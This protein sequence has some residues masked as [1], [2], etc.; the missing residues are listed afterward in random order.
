MGATSADAGSTG[1][2]ARSFGARYVP[3]SDE[4]GELR[5]SGRLTFAETGALWSTLAE[6]QDEACKGGRVD[7]NLEQVELL[8]GGAMA[9]LANFRAHLQERGVRS[10]FLGASE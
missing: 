6:V 9:L 3:H 2:Q 5:L 1:D 8:D 7:V 4:R 10:E